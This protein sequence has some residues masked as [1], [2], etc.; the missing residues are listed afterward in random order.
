MFD[1][2]G[3]GTCVV[4]WFGLFLPSRFLNPQWP[5]GPCIPRS[6]ISSAPSAAPSCLTRALDVVTIKEVGIERGSVVVMGGGVRTWPPRQKV[7]RTAHEI[8][9]AD[10]E[11]GQRNWIPGLSRLR[12][13]SLVVWWSIVLGSTSFTAPESRSI[14]HQQ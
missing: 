3:C 9:G 5:H 6:S 10:V 2:R 8:T 12:H 7:M 1:E 4:G 13:P 11:D 14:E